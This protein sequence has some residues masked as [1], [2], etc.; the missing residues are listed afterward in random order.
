MSQPGDDCYFYFCSVSGKVWLGFFVWFFF[1]CLT[2]KGRDGVGGALLVLCA[3][4][5]R[6]G[7]VL[8]ADSLG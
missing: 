1:L 3:L 7:S 2:F 8:T 5:K 4:N 6:W